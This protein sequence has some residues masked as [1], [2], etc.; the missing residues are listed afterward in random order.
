V[1][2]AGADPA[3]Q[4]AADEHP[5]NLSTATTMGATADH[6]AAASEQAGIDLAL[7]RAV[8]RH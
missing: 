6:I 3:A 7:P 4:I 2:E 1:L 8:Q 5:G